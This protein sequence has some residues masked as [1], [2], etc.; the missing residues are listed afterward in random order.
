MRFSHS[1]LISLPPEINVFW[2]FLFSCFSIFH[3]HICGHSEYQQEVSMSKVCKFALSLLLPCCFPQDKIPPNHAHYCSNPSVLLHYCC[4]SFLL[5]DDL[6]DDA[7]WKD[8]AT[9]SYT[10]NYSRYWQVVEVS[11]VHF[12]SHH[13]AYIPHLSWGTMEP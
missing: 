12:I 8:K 5:H 13:N 11:S 9:K 2:E 3:S 4:I 7:Q 10:L 1:A 6:F